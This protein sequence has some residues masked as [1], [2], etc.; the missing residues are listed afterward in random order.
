MADFNK[1]DVQGPPRWREYRGEMI[2][3][4]PNGEIQLKGFNGW[5]FSSFWGVICHI[6]EELSP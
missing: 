4:F 6:D 3:I 2:L 5:S 1:E